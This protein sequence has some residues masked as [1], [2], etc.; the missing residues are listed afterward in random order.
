M[1]KIAA[2]T[3]NLTA[4]LRAMFSAKAV[5]PMLAQR[6]AIELPANKRR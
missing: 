6:S 1:E 4:V 3:P 2:G 5:F